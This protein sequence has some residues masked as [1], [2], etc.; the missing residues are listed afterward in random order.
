M[1]SMKDS[2]TTEFFSTH[3]AAQQELQAGIAKRP[4]VQVRMVHHVKNNELQKKE[5]LLMTAEKRRK[6]TFYRLFPTRID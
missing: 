6:E 3:N 4:C 2:R 1:Y 5:K